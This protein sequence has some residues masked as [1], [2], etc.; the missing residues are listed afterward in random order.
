MLSTLRKTHSFV[1]RSYI[2]VTCHSKSIYSTHNA[3][4]SSQQNKMT[5]IIDL[6]DYEL[7]RN[8]AGAFGMQYIVSH[9]T[10][11][12]QNSHIL[13]ATSLFQQIMG[14]IAGADGL[15]KAEIQLLTE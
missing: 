9:P 15:S 1:H 4:S 12:I 5:A 7:E 8:N 11:R 3:M 2:A 13:K 10:T 14:F 6:W